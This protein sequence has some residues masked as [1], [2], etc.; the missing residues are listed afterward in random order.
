MPLG[1]Q[2]LFRKRCRV[3]RIKYSRVIS[4]PKLYLWSVLALSDGMKLISN[5]RFPS[6]E[7]ELGSQYET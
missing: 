3:G 6:E 4:T 1:S 7:V 5:P 2:F